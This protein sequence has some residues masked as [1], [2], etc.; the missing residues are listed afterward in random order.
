MDKE[1]KRYY[2][3]G[4]TYPIREE[5]KSRGFQWD[6]EANQWW[7]SKRAAAREAQQLV[8][9]RPGLDDVAGRAIEDLHA[10]LGDRIER[11]HVPTR[12]VSGA[13]AVDGNVM[14]GLHPGRGGGNHRIGG[15]DDVSG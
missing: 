1:P 9:R 13:L 14:A 3:E 2:L 4:N 5:L 11:R 6:P 12:P 8:E 15:G 10:A 7:H